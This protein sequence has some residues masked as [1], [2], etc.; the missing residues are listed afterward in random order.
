MRLEDAPAVL[1]IDEAA[2]ILRIGRTAAY[3]AA[4][5]G[6]LPAVR[7]GRRLLVPRLALEQLLGVTD[8]SKNGGGGTPPP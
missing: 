3:A 6:E 4:R 7:I 5:T 1:T 2:G 8:A